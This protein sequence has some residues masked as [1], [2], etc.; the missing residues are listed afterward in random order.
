MV[1]VEVPTLAVKP[2][3]APTTS[4]MLNGSA[5]LA[6]P[7]RGNTQRA[8][9]YV[10]GGLGVMGLATGGFLSYR[11]YDLNRK[12]LEQCRA[13]DPN[14]CTAEGKDRRDDAKFSATGATVAI[15]AGAALLASGIVLIVRAPRAEQ[16][17]SLVHDVRL[18]ASPSLTGGSVRLLGKW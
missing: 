2:D 17:S 7:G 8:I 1:S 9:G 16:K 13:D 5:D 12:S 10:V 3:T 15:A 14:A 11:A 4:V 18:L 6:M